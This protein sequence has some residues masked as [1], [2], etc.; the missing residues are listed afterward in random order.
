MND[1]RTPWLTLV[2]RS[3]SERIA[4]DPRIPAEAR[5]ALRDTAVSVL[6]QQF[7]ALMGGERVYAPRVDES[8]RQA[9]R[10]RIAAA[11]AAGEA[12]RVIARREGCSLRWVYKLRSATECTAAP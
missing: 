7:S 6:H 8:V 9:Q 11:L 3:A 10:Q 4:A 5:A 12:P 1:R 2:I